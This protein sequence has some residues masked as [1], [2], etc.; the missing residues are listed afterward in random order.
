MPDRIQPV[1]PD[2]DRRWQPVYTA[3]IVCAIAVMV[4][5]WAFSRI[6]APDAG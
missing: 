1:E 3:V 5:L 2:D 6:F 4:L